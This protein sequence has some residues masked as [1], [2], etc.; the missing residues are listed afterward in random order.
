MAEAGVAARAAAANEMAEAAE[1]GAAETTRAI[2]GLA[3]GQRLT[4]K[5]F[6]NLQRGI[7]KFAVNEHR[8]HGENEDLSVSRDIEGTKCSSGYRWSHKTDLEHEAH[9]D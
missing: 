5:R 7:R 6:P 9:G 3:N 4:R 1:V 2:G 8:I